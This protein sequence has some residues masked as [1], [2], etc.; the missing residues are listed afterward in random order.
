MAIDLSWNFL[1]DPISPTIQSIVTLL[2][3]PLPIT[4]HEQ[5]MAWSM[6]VIGCDVMLSRW[7]L[8][9]TMMVIFMKRGP[10]SVQL[11]NNDGVKSFNRLRTGIVVE[12]QTCIRVWDIPKQKP[13][14][15]N[16]AARLKIVSWSV[17]C[18]MTHEG[19]CRVQRRGNQT[20]LLYL[21]MVVFNNDIN[22]DYYYYY[23][24]YGN[25][26]TCATCTFV[27]TNLH[28]RHQTITLSVIVRKN[29]SRKSFKSDKNYHWKIKWDVLRT[30]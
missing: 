6:I 11:V 1:Q 29:H 18:C 13:A 4:T 16:R 24:N 2:S 12:T 9:P 25:N 27:Y 28:P 10:G 5:K 8:L 20:C 7:L 15:M 19:P 30:L 3:I 17:T 21:Q 23:N 22:N 26:N 14:R